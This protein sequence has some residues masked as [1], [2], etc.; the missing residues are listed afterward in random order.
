M[1]I[2][3]IGC[4]AIGRVIV[5]AFAPNGIKGIRVVAVAE[6]FP[7]QETV[8]L[9]RS[10]GVPLVADPEELLRFSPDLI[11]EAADQEAVRKYAPLF[12]NKGKDMMILSV[13]AL[14]DTRFFSE[15]RDLALAK[16]ARIIVPSGAIGGLDAIKSAA[17]GRLTEVTIRNIK[18][19]AGLEGAPYVLRKG[20]DLKS[21]KERTEIY[22]GFADEAAKEFPKNVNVAVAL[23][24]AGIGPEKTRVIV[25]V[26]PHEVCNVH[27]IKAKGDFGEAVFTVSGLPS[28][29]NPR[30]SY[31]AALSAIATLQNM[32]NPVRVGT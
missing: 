9:L 28:P 2:A 17:V 4:G 20:I 21:I 29:D 16:G 14:A 18:P 13:G 8:G 19:P 25:I 6:T 23:S 31:L 24:L 12:I 1:N 5:K 30:T 3:L 7:T 11:V 22:D 15:V 10:A 32:V 27:E 26:D